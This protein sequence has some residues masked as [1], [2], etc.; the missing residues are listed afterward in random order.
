[1]R[2]NV[3]G[4]GSTQCTSDRIADERAELKERQLS[5][6]SCITRNKTYLSLTS[7]TSNPTLNYFELNA[8]VTGEKPIFYQHVYDKVTASVV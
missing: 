5:R 3:D 8:R 7:F 1:L 4:S 6:D 2:Y